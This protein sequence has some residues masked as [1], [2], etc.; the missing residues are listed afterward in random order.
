MINYKGDLPN[1]TP[2]LNIIDNDGNYPSGKFRNESQ[3]DNTAGTTI[4]AEMFN[5]LYALPYYLMQEH[6][7]KLFG[8]TTPSNE[9][10]FSRGSSH[11]GSADTRLET[12]HAN[13]YQMW[14]LFEEFIRPVGKV[15][16]EYQALSPLT[17]LY[18]DLIFTRSPSAYRGCFFRVENSG[19][20][21]GVGGTAKWN[22]TNPHITPWMMPEIYGELYLPFGGIRDQ[23]FLTDSSGEFLTLG[24]EKNRNLETEK[25]TLSIFEDTLFDG[26]DFSSATYGSSSAMMRLNTITQFYNAMIDLRSELIKLHGGNFDLNDEGNSFNRFIALLRSYGSQRDE[27]AAD[28]KRD[29]LHQ[30]VIDSAYMPHTR[31][32][33]YNYLADGLN[34]GFSESELRPANEV[35]I[36]PK[37]MTMRMYIKTGTIFKPQ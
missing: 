25:R 3:I 8:T 35:E 31:G 36:A 2:K 7:M 15:F 13:S 6:G 27:H 10:E 9:E 17:T 11:T 1:G 20:A 26:R 32:H 16:F 33:T 5:E 4:R 18:P 29:L 34:G 12:S 19:T 14:Q 23:D 24:R 37:H 21:T 28:P 22:D 30:I